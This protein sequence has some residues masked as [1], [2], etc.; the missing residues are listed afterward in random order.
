MWVQGW[1]EGSAM[2]LGKVLVRWSGIHRHPSYHRSKR[3]WKWEAE[4]YTR[5]LAIPHSTWM[6]AFNKNRSDEQRVSRALSKLLSPVHSPRPPE[7]RRNTPHQCHSIRAD[8]SSLPHSGS[9]S[10]FRMIHQIVHE[11]SYLPRNQSATKGRSQYS[12]IV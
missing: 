3:D 11:R 12:D 8:C 7:Q 10:R 6:N 9:P 1:A 2:V 4:L 5:R